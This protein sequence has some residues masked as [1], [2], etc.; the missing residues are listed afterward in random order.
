ME[1]NNMLFEKEKRKINKM[2]I[3]GKSIMDIGERLGMSYYYVQSRIIKSIKN[4]DTTSIELGYKDAPYYDTEEE[5]L[6]EKEYNYNTLSNDEKEIYD[7]REA[8]G[9]LGRYFA[10]NDGLYGGHQG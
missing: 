8:A 9:S 4:I 3:D 1:Q 6:I 10:S 5:M 2:V 7:Q